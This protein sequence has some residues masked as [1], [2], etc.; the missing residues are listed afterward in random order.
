MTTRLFMS[1]AS[2]LATS[3]SMVVLPTPGRPRRSTLLPDWIR[4]SIIFIVPKTARPT[5]Q[6]SPIMRPLRLRIAE[7]RCRV[8]SMPARLSSPKLL[9][10]EAT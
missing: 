5:R 4:S 9:T 10:R 8:R 2:T 3:R 1:S 7:I 6:V